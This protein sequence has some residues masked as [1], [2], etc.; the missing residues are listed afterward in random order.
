MGHK[1]R[2]RIHPPSVTIPNVP[3]APINNLV[4]SNPAADFLARL[5]VLITLPLGR[6]TVWIYLVKLFP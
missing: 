5:R 1:K 6:T 3:S 2:Y 4:V